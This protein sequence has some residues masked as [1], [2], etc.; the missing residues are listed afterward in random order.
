LVIHQEYE[1]AFLP[2]SPSMQRKNS[3]FATLKKTRLQVISILWSRK[4]DGNLE[5]HSSTIDMF[6]FP[7]DEIHWNFKS[8]INV[9]LKPAMREL[10]IHVR[11][12][13]GKRFTKSLHEIT[14]IKL[15]F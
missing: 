14:L 6:L 3:Q 13:N 1:E 9:L 8:I 15:C 4:V 11:S 2:R 10:I 7:I 12:H 5:G